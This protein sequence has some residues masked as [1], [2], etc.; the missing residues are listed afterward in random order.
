MDNIN[1]YEGISFSELTEE[2]INSLSEKDLLIKMLSE[3]VDL[4]NKE[5]DK[6]LNSIKHINGFGVITILL[7]ILYGYI[8]LFGFIPMVLLYIYHLKVKNSLKWAVKSFK[9]NIALFRYNGQFCIENDY[10]FEDHINKIEKVDIG[11]F[12]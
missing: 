7:T 1:K 3:D 8:G 2:Q 12:Y 4:I 9:I 10:I 5:G 6:Y 11:K